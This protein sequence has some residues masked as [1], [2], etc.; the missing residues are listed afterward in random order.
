MII[1]YYVVYEA[2]KNGVSVGKGDCEYY[3]DKRFTQVSEIHKACEE[4]KSNY[5]FEADVNIQILNYIFL[6]QEGSN[7]YSPTTNF[8]H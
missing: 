2:W 4:I 1:V 5:P 8:I 6:R 3:A 7:A